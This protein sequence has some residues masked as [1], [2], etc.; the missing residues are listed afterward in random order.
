[1]THAI[2]QRKTNCISIAEEVLDRS[3]QKATGAGLCLARDIAKTS[4]GGIKKGRE[5][6]LPASKLNFPDCR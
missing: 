5:E 4:A 6:K 3:H 1:M 2:N